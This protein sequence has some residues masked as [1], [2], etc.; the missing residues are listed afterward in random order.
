MD[1]EEALKNK[2]EFVRMRS[3][4]ENWFEDNNECMLNAVSEQQPIPLARESN[5]KYNFLKMLG[6]S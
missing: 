4:S 1:Y 5:D 6:G 2:S 3:K